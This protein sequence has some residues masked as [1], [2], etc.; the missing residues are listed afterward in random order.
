MCDCECCIYAKTMHLYL[1]SWNNRY[2][3]KL[4][5]KSKI[6]KTEGL[7]KWIVVYLKPI[8]IK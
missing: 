3:K 1:L 2:L 4:N 7:A 5:S 6:R 8:R